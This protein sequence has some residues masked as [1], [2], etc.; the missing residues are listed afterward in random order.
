MHFVALQSASQPWNAN[1]QFVE[2]HVLL[3]VFELFIFVFL[4]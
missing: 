4:V 2:E 3:S 1:S